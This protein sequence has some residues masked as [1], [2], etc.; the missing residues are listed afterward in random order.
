MSLPFTY[1]HVKREKGSWIKPIQNPTTGKFWASARTWWSNLS[2]LLSQ[3][4]VHG[5]THY[6]HI[7]F[8][9]KDTVNTSLYDTIPLNVPGRTLFG[10]VEAENVGLDITEHPQELQELSVSTTSVSNLFALFDEYRIE[11]INHTFM[12]RNYGEPP[13]RIMWRLIKYDAAETAT[14]LNDVAN[15]LD[16][17]TDT[18]TPGGLV[19]FRDNDW[20]TLNIPGVE[21]N[22]TNFYV[23]RSIPLKANILQLFPDKDMYQSGREAS[24]SSFLA[25]GPRV[26]TNA[27]GLQVAAIS[28]VPNGQ[29]IDATDLLMATS[30]NWLYKVRKTNTG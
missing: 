3:Q 18:T 29:G 6:Q 16:E 20:N 4:V 8:Q 11:A 28:D 12:F 10:T 14:T 30:F 13:L 9:I 25:S 2:T 21:K 17:G 22:G 27:V 15:A 7:A 1:R 19:L 5:G 24:F 26:T 23:E